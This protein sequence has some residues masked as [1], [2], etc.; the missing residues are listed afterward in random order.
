MVWHGMAWRVGCLEADHAGVELHVDLVFEIVPPVV[1]AIDHGMACNTWHGMHGMVWYACMPWYAW[2]G[3]EG[4]MVLEIVSPV[5]HGIAWHDIAWHG[6]P[7]YAVVHTM[8]C[9]RT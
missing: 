2:H 3:M 7:C 8:L 4:G 5:V 9:H 1:P 6:I